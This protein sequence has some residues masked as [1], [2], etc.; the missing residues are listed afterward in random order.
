MD[1][2]TAGVEVSAWSQELVSSETGSAGLSIVAGAAGSVSAIDIRGETTATISESDITSRGNVQVLATDIADVTTR[3]GAIS[4]GLIAGV[5]GAI[6]F[7]TIAR[8]TRA[9]MI[10]VHSNAL[11]STE[12]IAYSQ[13]TDRWRC[14][15]G[16]RRRHRRRRGYRCGPPHRRHHRGGH[17]GGHRGGVS[18]L[19]DQPGSGI[20]PGPMSSSRPPITPR[21]SEMRAAIAEAWG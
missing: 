15:H 20:S 9:K 10:G 14:R 16:R 3:A 4:V 2:G 12:V 8:D 1:A 19:R 21:S 17:H 6:D 5:G 18:C 13:A 7:V 11:G